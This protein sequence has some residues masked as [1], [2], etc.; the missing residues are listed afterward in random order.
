MNSALQTAIRQIVESVLAERDVASVE[1]VHQ[2]VSES[3]AKEL[4]LSSSSTV[5]T[6]NG[7]LSTAVPT[8]RRGRGRKATLTP[9]EKKEK[10]RIWQQQHRAKKK[11]EKAAAAGL[12]GASH[13]VP[14]APTAPTAPAS[15]PVEERPTIAFVPEVDMNI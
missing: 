14:T 7:A 13:A 6:T 8:V 1:T 15:A 5:E 11:A 9:E 2:I 4:G 12:N 10:Q 3:I